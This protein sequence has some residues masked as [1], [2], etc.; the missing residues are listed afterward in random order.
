MT[1]GE[2]VHPCRVG[3]LPP[4]CAAMCRSNVTVQELAVKAILE[5]D[6]EAAF[7]ALALD[8]S[9]GAVLTLKQA[10]R[11][12]DEMWEAEGALLDYYLSAAGHGRGRVR[13]TA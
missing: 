5:R 1:D 13:R 11:M 8:P 4:Q 9:V 6:R 3:D 10:R 2:G 12:F 7:H